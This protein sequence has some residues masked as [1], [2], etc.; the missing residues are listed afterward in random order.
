VKPYVIRRLRPSLLTPVV[1]LLVFFVGLPQLGWPSFPLPIVAVF[2]G[3]FAWSAWS[4]TLVLRIDADGVL[5]VRG[6]GRRGRRDESRV[7]WPSIHEVV[8]TEGEPPTFF[9]R[10][11][12]DASLPDGAQAVIHDPEREYAAPPDL[13]IRL[14]SVNRAELAQ[15]VEGY[16]RVPLRSS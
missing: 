5:L 13:Q 8:L 6:I 9:L 1:F 12:P 16:G 14:R 7:P 4:S 11:K 3:L 2:T 15:A 10:L